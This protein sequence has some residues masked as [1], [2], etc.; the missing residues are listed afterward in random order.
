MSLLYSDKFL[1]LCLEAYKLLFAVSISLREFF[2]ILSLL[3]ALL[4]DLLKLL[5]LHNELVLKRRVLRRVNPR[6]V[7]LVHQHALESQ[8]LLTIRR[9]LNFKL[10]YLRKLQRALK[11]L[12]FCLF[13]GQ[14]ALQLLNPL[15]ELRVLLD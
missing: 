9:Q 15:P 13:Q 7:S 11:V 2:N 14:V 10:F 4:H 3:F 12:H 8:D 5:T 6:L 1:Q